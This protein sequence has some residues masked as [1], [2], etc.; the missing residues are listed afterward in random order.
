MIFKKLST[1][2]VGIVFLFVIA[3]FAFADDQKRL[4]PKF[5]FDVRHDISLPWRNIPQK[6]PEKGQPNKAS[7]PKLPPGL[8]GKPKPTDAGLDPARQ[9]FGTA[10]TP[11]PSSSFEGLSDDD[12]AAT[13]G[14]RFVPP[15][16]NGQD[17]VVFVKPTM[18]EIPSYFTIILLTDGYSVNL[19][20]ALA[21]INV[22]RFQHPPIRPVH[23]IVMTSM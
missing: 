19:Q 6:G 23:T 13:I 11:L 22:L 8:V 17:L 16:T 1:I 2:L 18:M 21:D 12:N 10:A 3:Q 20:L 15:D 4:T 9:P 14:G 5:S 7:K